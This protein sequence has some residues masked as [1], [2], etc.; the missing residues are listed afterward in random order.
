M[1]THRVFNLR[2]EQEYKIYYPVL[3]EWWKEWGFNP[4]SPAM[5]S[6]NGIMIFSNQ[7][8]ICAGWLYRTDSNTA[9]AGWN[10]SAKRHKKHRKGCVEKLIEE[11]ENLARKLGF[12]ILNYPASNPNLRNKLEKKGFGDYADKNITNYFKS[13]WEVQREQ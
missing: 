9:V 6:E 3:A 8:P 10:I 5:L 1:L 7:I 13:L 11:L 4:L 12:E 2:N